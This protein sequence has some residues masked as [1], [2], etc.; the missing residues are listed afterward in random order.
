MEKKVSV[1]LPPPLYRLATNFPARFRTISARCRRITTARI[2]RK[3]RCAGTQCPMQRVRYRGVNARARRRHVR[4][5]E[6]IF[7]TM[8]N[9]FPAYVLRRR[10][11][12]DRAVSF[13]LREKRVY[14]RQTRPEQTMVG[15]PRRVYW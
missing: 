9:I 13:S 7:L 15:I 8:A 11:P 4:D 14:R 5:V 12:V 10:R 6:K 1:T 3:V 2:L